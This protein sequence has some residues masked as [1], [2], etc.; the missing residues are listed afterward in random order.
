MVLT[1]LVHFVKELDEAKKD[2]EEEEEEGDE[3][4]EEEEDGDDEEDD[5]EEEG[6]V[7]GDVADPEQVAYMQALKSDVK[8]MASYALQEVDGDELDENM[9]ENEDEYSSPIDDVNE[10][11]VFYAAFQAANARA[12]HLVAALPPDVQ[13]ACAALL[14]K[15]HA[16]A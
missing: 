6:G 1:K 9:Y 15:A 2:D 7:E 12:P 5:D 3:D 4:E 16:S 10:L 14:Q 11:S 13:A 8:K